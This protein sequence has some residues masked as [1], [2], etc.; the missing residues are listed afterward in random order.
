TFGR[1]QNG[2]QVSENPA[3]RFI[4][5]LQAALASGRAHLAATDSGKPEADQ[6]DACGWRDGEAQGD[7]I[8]WIDGDDVFLQ[9]DAA[10]RCVQAMASNG[11][12]VTVA[13]KTLWKRLKEAGL[14]ASVGSDDRQMVRKQIGQTRL[15]VLHLKAEK[16]SGSVEGKKSGQSGQ[17][18]HG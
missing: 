3:L 5:L 15:R 4:E 10:Y 7:R 18:G 6:V 1:T 8:G 13:S 11:E 9:P 12:G 14:L 2:Y 16:L 17:S